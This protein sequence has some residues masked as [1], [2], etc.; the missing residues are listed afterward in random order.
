VGKVDSNAATSCPICSISNRSIEGIDLKSLR[1]ETAWLASGI[2]RKW[3]ASDFVRESLGDDTV[4]EM[5]PRVTLKAAPS[6]KPGVA[7]NS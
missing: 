2:G 6:P 4:G 5:E 3:C 1:R 7:L